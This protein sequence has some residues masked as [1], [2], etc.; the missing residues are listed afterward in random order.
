MTKFLQKVVDAIYEYGKMGA[1]EASYRGIYE[2]EVPEDLQKLE[3]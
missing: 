3:N 2:K 1:G